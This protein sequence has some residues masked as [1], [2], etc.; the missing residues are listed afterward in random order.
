MPGFEVFGEEEQNAINEIFDK[1]GGILFAHGFDAMQNSIYRV[2]EFEKAF[3]QRLGAPYAQAVS[4]GTAALKV[5]LKAL[6][7]GPEIELI[8]EQ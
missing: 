5:G 6:G 3:A 7:V 4:S 8:D 2:R 1:N